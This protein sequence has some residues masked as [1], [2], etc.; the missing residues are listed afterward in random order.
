MT[1]KEAAGRRLADVA[2]REGDVTTISLSEPVEPTRAS[3]LYEIKGNHALTGAAVLSGGSG[4]ATKAA[5]SAEIGRS[6]CTER[7]TRVTLHSL[8]S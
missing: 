8:H 3:E 5:A 2:M 6:L 4:R 7:S 1:S